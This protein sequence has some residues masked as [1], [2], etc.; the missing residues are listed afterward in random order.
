MHLIKYE[1]RRLCGVMCLLLDSYVNNGFIC[2]INEHQNGINFEAPAGF[3]H[4]ML[5]C[6]CSRFESEISRLRILKPVRVCQGCYAILKTQHHH[7]DFA[8]T[9]SSPVSNTSPTVFIVYMHR[10]VVYV[11]F[12]QMECGQIYPN[13]VIYS[14]SFPFMKEELLRKRYI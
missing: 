6:R 5:F 8:G 10:R 14:F 1:G 2:E 13:Q 11:V 3:Q 7:G 9:Q 4:K 12:L